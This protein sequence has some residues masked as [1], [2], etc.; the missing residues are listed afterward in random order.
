MSAELNALLRCQLTAVNQQFVHILALRCWGRE[1]LALHIAAVDNADFPGA[2][3]LMQRL[4]SEGDSL[5]IEAETFSPGGDPKEVF[6]A[7]RA[8]ESRM[9]RCLDRAADEGAVGAYA[10]KHAT[11]PRDRYW[12]WL[13]GPETHALPSSTVVSFPGLSKL[14]SHLIVMIEQSM[15]HAFIHRRQGDD[16]AADRAW[17]ASGEAMMK[18]TNLV[19]TCAALSGMPDPNDPPKLQL[20]D[21]LSASEG[22]DRELALSCESVAH[23]AASDAAHASVKECCEDIRFY[24]RQV[25]NWHSGEKHP[26]IGQNRAFNSFSATYEK[27][28]EPLDNELATR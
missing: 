7:E 8:I 15:A 24:A 11:A 18:M 2:M 14:F 5:K 4:L 3:W 21:T 19:R 27:Y 26:A 6:E 12:N 22:F 28:V 20:G 17:A 1:D 10:V 23:N 13:E 25:A 16:V 9:R